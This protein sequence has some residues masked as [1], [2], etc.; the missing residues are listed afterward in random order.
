MHT[1]TWIFEVYPEPART[2]FGPA[3][4]VGAKLAFVFNNFSFI[5]IDKYFAFASL[6]KLCS[7]R[8]KFQLV[9][10]NF[11]FIGSVKNGVKSYTFWNNKPR[12]L[13]LIIWG[14]VSL[15]QILQCEKEVHKP[16][17][18]RSSG[19]WNDTLAKVIEYQKVVIHFDHCQYLPNFDFVKTEES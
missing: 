16:Y 3:A 8:A 19:I 14:W 12:N 6:I 13:L 17:W 5:F 1:L 2:D 9:I 10:S 4:S 7:Y 11:I 18:V 15:K